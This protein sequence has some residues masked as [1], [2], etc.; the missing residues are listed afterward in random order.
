MKRFLSLFA[1]ICA[2]C[3]VAI[4]KPYTISEIPNVQLSDRHRYTS[5]PDG[6]L[7]AEAV[8]AIDLA[9]DSLRTKGAAQIAVVAVK[10]IASDDV[11]LFAHKLFSSWGVGLDKSDNGLGILLV[12]DKREIRFV[13]GYGLE[14]IL[15]DAICK[16]I[17]QRY[18]VEP[19]GNGNYDKG[20]VDGVAAVATLLSSGELPAT[21]EDEITGVEIAAIFGTMIAFFVIF[22]LLAYCINRAAHRCPKCGKYH[23]KIVDTHVVKNARTYR[24]IDQTFTCPDC[25][26][27]LIRHTRQE[28]PS[29]IL[30][31]G[32]GGRGGFGGGGF[33]G[34]FGGG[35]F[36]GGGAGSKF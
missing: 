29:V 20:M 24:L 33:G 15:P 35:S 14:G 1:L 2:T 22:A 34:G 3:A 36:G 10:D 12:L 11:F 27:T 6:I 23:L 5:N 19:L 18:M 21:A 4:A 13:T 28:K 7:S 17:Q 31:G 8:Q 32:G 26:H 25:G 30:T 16:R 9:C